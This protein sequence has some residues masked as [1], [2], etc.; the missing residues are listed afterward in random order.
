MS[1]ILHTSG[2]TDQP[3]QIKHSWNYIKECAQ[4]SIKEIGLTS[5]DRV[6]DVFPGN[7]IAH[8]TITAYPALLSGAE[9]HTAVFNPYEYIE[10]FKHIQP[11]YISLIPRHLEVLEKTKG[12]KDLDMSSVRYMVTGS[13]KIEQKFIDAFRSKGVQTVANW[14]GM[15]EAPPP[16]MV[17]YNTTSF[18]FNTINSQRYHVM[19]HPITATSSLAECIINGRSTG[20]IFD[21]STKEFHS[22]RI[23]S[24]GKTW[25]THV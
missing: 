2:S 11:T 16:I 5:E 20:D 4:Q 9:L 17:G 1:L 7:T 24:N 14:Y 3:K 8:Y 10:C 15:T 6:L 12:F 22:R 18:D 21:M 19:F 25:K 13:S 23:E